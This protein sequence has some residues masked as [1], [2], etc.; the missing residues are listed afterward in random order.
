MQRPAGGNVGNRTGDYTD[1]HNLGESGAGFVQSGAR[2][3]SDPEAPV[4]LFCRRGVVTTAERRQP[5]Q[6]LGAQPQRDAAQCHLAV[7]IGGLRRFGD[8][9]HAN[10][11]SP[12]VGPNC[13][14]LPARNPLVRG[15]EAGERTSTLCLPGQTQ[16]NSVSKSTNCSLR[17]RSLTASCVRPNDTANVSYTIP[18]AHRQPDAGLEC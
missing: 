11:R 18:A 14:S 15:G 13:G 3:E 4:L 7:G 5:P 6:V 2:T 12:I 17:C 1:H 9:G 8:A 16:L 10:C